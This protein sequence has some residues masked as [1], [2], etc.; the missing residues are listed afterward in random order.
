MIPFSVKQAWFWLALVGLA[1]CWLMLLVLGRKYGGLWGR[2]YYCLFVTLVE[3]IFSL[4][5][6]WHMDPKLMP[7]P[8]CI[9]QVVSFSLGSFALTG[10]SASFAVANALAVFRP[11]SFDTGRAILAWHPRYIPL[12]ILFPLLATV[13][14]AS[15]LIKLNAV[16]PALADDMHCDITKPMWVRLFGYAGVPLAVS[17]PFLCLSLITAIRLIR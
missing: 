7:H 10:V 8:F 1:Q 12:V 9:A 2:L 13:L 11:Q 3:G 17:L 4:G 5:M 16:Q 14:H 6:I 15:L